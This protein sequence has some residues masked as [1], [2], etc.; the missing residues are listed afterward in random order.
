MQLPR[1]IMPQ[2]IHSQWVHAMQSNKACAVQKK[3]EPKNIYTNDQVWTSK[4]TFVI[5]HLKL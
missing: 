5:E 3:N 2:S 1:Y 4:T